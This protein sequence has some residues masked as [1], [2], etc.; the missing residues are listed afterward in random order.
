[1]RTAT[2]A[3]SFRQALAEMAAHK[4]R[5][6][7]TLL[8]MVFGVGAVIAM[9][10]VGEGAQEESMR[11]IDTMGVRNLVVNA[12]SF[13]ED[14]LQEN[15][16]DSLGLTRSDMRAAVETLNAVEAWGAEK[17]IK[18]YD[19]FSLHGRSD[20]SVY[21]VS[22]R[23]FDLSNLDAAAGSL[24][25]DDAN[26]AYEQ[27]A[28]LGAQAA[29]DLFPGED[30]IGGRIKVNPL[31]LR[32]VGVL[33]DRNLSQDE[34]QGVK[35]GDERNRVFLPLATALK[36]LKFDALEDE[37]DTFRV[38]LAE[39]QDPEVGALALS[40]LMER[41]H[42][43]IDDFELV[44]PAAL[45][46]QQQQTQRIFTIV[47]SC[48]AGISLL[49]GGIGIMNIM[50]ATILERTGEIGLL[51]ALGAR[52]AYIRHQFLVE[53]FTISASGALLG[54]VFGLLL[55]L[56][57]QQLAGWAVGWSISAILLA[58][59]ICLV[60]GVLFGWYPASRAADLDPIRALQSDPV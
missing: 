44:V 22:P 21:A 2:L 53:S 38:R 28:V 30:P 49:V 31:W 59:V 24:F 32:V 25:D 41:R 10:S 47:M 34:F 50:L 3:S 6:L 45:L 4:L 12:R 48:I 42:G 56:A 1:M 16:K 19:L 60:T 17:Q 26:R 33:E 57:I 23:I 18:T 37:I 5:T 7:L 39:G 8:G 15:R 11:M 40:H 52:K 27:V 58:V 35:L 54:I 29:A 9:L 51:R 20:A 14:T 55:A 43:G 13:D 46:K 36:R